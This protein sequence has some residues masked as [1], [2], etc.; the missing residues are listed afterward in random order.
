MEDTFKVRVDKVFG[1]LSSSQ[2]SSPSLNS[3]WSLT[4][5]EIQRREWNRDRDSADDEPTSY[6]SNYDGFF[7]TQQH[8]RMSDKKPLAI[9][10][11]RREDELEKD[12]DDLDN[13]DDVD[14]DA[15]ASSMQSSK[16]DDHNDEEWEI[17]S[18]VGLDCTL[19]YEEEE[20]AFDK[21]AVGK[22]EDGDRMYMRDINDYGTCSDTY[23]ELPGSF[24]DVIRDPRANHLA[25][26]IRLKE[27]A[28]A[29]GSFDSLRVSDKTVPDVE[30]AQTNTFEDVVNLKSILK[31][32]QNQADSKSQKR[33]RFDPEC[34]SD[35]EESSGGGEEVAMET[36]VMEE[37]TI[38]EEVSEQPLLHPGVPDYLRNPSKYTC[39]TF[40]S[41]SEIDEVSNRQACMNFLN[42]L[43]RSD[44]MESQPFE[45]PKSVIFTPKRKTDNASTVKSCTEFNQNQED[46]G[47]GSMQRKGLPVGIAA[48]DVRESEICAMEEDEPEAV[49]DKSNSSRKPRR[50][51]RMK[52][53]LEMDDFRF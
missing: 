6:P 31:R 29:A 11:E 26:K 33:V 48:A 37:A 17:R 34:K 40:D 5:E 19:D 25:A 44:T 36:C 1:S 10:K 27:D 38:S 53:S 35:H 51:Y 21:V 16:P 8:R 39:Y 28:E 20:D 52:A 42:S 45:L 22:E 4:D 9:G 24:G 13:G 3:L 46:T 2:S 41:T 30:S 7:A 15:P 47:K 18:S 14:E 23:D 12:L 43:R 50:K 32:K 49:A